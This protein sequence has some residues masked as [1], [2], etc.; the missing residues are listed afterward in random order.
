MVKQNRVSGGKLRCGSGLL[1]LLEA[2]HAVALQDRAEGLFQLQ[3]L[4]TSPLPSPHSH[5]TPPP[6]F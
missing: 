2:G 5:T 1:P 6:S 4:Q 3:V